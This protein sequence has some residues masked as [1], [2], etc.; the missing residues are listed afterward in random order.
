MPVIRKK[1]RQHAEHEAMVRELVRHLKATEDEVLPEQPRI[2]EETV[3]LSHALRVFVVWD[4]WTEIA[5]QR[6]RDEIILEAY[7]QAL[8]RESMARISVVRGLTRP[9]TLEIGATHLLKS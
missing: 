5:E 6:E 7:D 3:P 4:R 9:E 8:G 2:I 1:P